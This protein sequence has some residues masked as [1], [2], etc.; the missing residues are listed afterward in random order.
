MFDFTRIREAKKNKKKLD[1]KEEFGR[2]E[3]VFLIGQSFL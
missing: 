1:K 3:I 2:M